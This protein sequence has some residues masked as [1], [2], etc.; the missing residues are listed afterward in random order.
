MYWCGISTSTVINLLLKLYTNFGVLLEAI[1]C[2]PQVV[3]LIFFLIEDTRG[4]QILFFFNS[5]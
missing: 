5:K 4:R 2:G 3:G 1:Q